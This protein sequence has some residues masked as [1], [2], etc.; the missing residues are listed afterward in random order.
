MGKGN[1]VHG[2]RAASKGKLGL[3]QF[4]CGQIVTISFR[5]DKV[6]SDEGVMVRQAGLLIPHPSGAEKTFALV[7]DAGSNPGEGLVGASKKFALAGFTPD[8]VALVG[9]IIDEKDLPDISEG[10]ALPTAGDQG[11][12]PQA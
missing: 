1:R 11:E 12:A 9:A 3:L 7:T 6:I 4:H 2:K 5:A 10:P 8:E